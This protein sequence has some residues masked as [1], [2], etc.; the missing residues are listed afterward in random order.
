MKQSRAT[1]DLNTY[2]YIRLRG[3]VKM[4]NKV[5]VCKACGRE[6]CEC[7]ARYMEALKYSESSFGIM[8]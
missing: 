1:I 3:D 8:R 7:K 6:P 4:E 5:K 2:I